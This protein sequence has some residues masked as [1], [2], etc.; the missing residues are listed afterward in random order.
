M[1][2]EEEKICLKAQ[3]TLT[4]KEKTDKLKCM[5]IKNF[6]KSSPHNRRSYL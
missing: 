6:I 4:T 3:K 2:L 5:I 1:I